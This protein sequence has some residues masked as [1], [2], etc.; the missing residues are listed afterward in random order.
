[1]TNPVTLNL[2]K[3]FEGFTS[4]AK[5]DVNAYR[6]GYGSDT[7]TLPNGTVQKVSPGTVESEPDAE[8]DLV[9]RLDTH[10]VP[11]AAQQVGQVQFSKFSV[12]TQAALVSLT[13]NF[14]SL[15][16]VV[17]SAAK[18]GS[19]AKIKIAILSL[20][21]ENRGVNDHRRQ[22]EADMVT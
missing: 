8:R 13:Y 20:K 17:V 21:G 7:I 9:R 12:R 19:L 10:F 5:W 14:G 2:I 18:T 11:R 15:P 22:Q 4:H 1:M 3:S 6:V 16:S